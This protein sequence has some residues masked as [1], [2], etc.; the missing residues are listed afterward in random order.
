MSVAPFPRSDDVHVLVVEDNEVDARIVETVLRHASFAVRRAGRLSEALTALRSGDFDVVLCDL[1]LPDSDGLATVQTLMR[2]APAIPLVVMTGRNDESIALRAVAAGAQDYLVKG[3]TDASVLARSI[4]YAVERGR[5]AR[6][7][8][9]ERLASERRLRALVEHASDLIYLCDETGRFTYVSPPVTR[10]FGYEPAELI[11]CDPMELVHPDDVEYVQQRFHTP[12]A[13]TSIPILAEFRFRH[14]N[15]TWRHLEVLRANRLFDPAVR[16]IVGNVRDVTGRRQVQEALDQLRRRYQ[17]ILNSIY[18]G[19]Q[20]VDL[21]GHITFEN[22]A[23]AALLG[24]RPT[25]MFGCAAHA[26]MHHSL[27]DGTPRSEAASP[28]HWTLADGIVR[29]VEDDVF[30]RKDGTALRVEYTVA[31]MVDEQGRVAG[32][33]ITFRDISKQ[34]QLEQQLEQDARVASLGRVSASVAHEFNNLLMSVSPFAEML[35]RKTLEDPTLEKPVKHVLNAVRRGQRL[36]DEI[37]RYTNPA[38][39]R[40][41]RLDVGALIRDF[42]EEAAGVLG[43]RRLEVDVPPALRVRADADQLTQVLLNLVTNARD[44]TEPG[45]VV[46]IGAAPAASV[47]FLRDRLSAPE[48]FAGVYVR[49]NGCGI[50]AEAQER[51][52]EPFFT[53]KKRGGTGLGLAVAHRIVAQHGGHIL[54]E[55]EVGAGTAFYVVL[56]T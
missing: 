5:A 38:E 23:A 2:E 33:V 54:I 31:P 28:I 13:Q 45:G 15:G 34:K 7:R 6:E 43:D 10:M 48:R 47:P 24:W 20:G 40:I 18:D 52:F 8:Q 9:E 36:T 32:A 11:G 30:W 12:A 26:T 56:P 46:T 41:T 27:P 1:G 42:T 53:A 4:R 49:D 22:P 50:S 39:P 51:I 35:R 55:S 3:S 16:A 21:A 14:K 25:E 19:V 29:F 44:A 17:L 37:L